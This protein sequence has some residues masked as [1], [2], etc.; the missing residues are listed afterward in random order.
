VLLRINAIADR[1]WT[2]FVLALL[3]AC[4][5]CG[6]DDGGGG[7]ASAGAGAAGGG[8][9]GGGTGGGSGGGTSPPVSPANR[10]PVIISALEAVFPTTRTGV[11]YRIVGS[12]P[13]GDSLTY[14][15]AGEDA[16]SFFVNS[17]TGEITFITAPDVDM[18]ASADGDNFYLIE[19]RAT[20]PSG[21]SAS[22]RLDIEVARHDPAGPT[23][24]RD[25][26]VFLAP[27]T[28]VESD[29]TALRNLTFLETAVRNIPDNRIGNAT[30]IEVNIFTA[31][32]DGGK[33]IEIMV[34]TEFSLSAAENQANLYARIVGQ[35]D[36]VLRE[37]VETIWIHAGNRLFSGP[38]GGIVV[39]TGQAQRDYIPRGVLEEVMAHEAVHASLDVLYLGAPAWFEAQ[40][41]DI[42]FVTDYARDF[43]ENEDLAES[44]GAYLIVKNAER[45]P[46]NIVT[47]IQE[48]IPQRLAFFAS[49]GL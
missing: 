16:G 45:N 5:A 4:A 20:D 2:A 22:Q 1:I 43:P 35:L 12:D 25:G 7:G 26:S 42:S 44:Y 23:L 27:N 3:V 9:T 49:L 48:G 30:D 19:V 37:G 21:A 38:V 28:I 15:I 34:N 40:K 24:F 47:R 6:G 33:R 17:G 36:P 32:Y 39:H 31:N 41:R 18:P 8:G 10:P 14:S 46:A 29:P 13:D 11:V